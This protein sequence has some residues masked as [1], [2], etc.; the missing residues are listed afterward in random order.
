MTPTIAHFTPTAHPSWVDTVRMVTARAKTMMPE[1]TERLE[2]AME[3]VLYGQVTPAADGHTATVTS[4][5]DTDT[6]TVN[7]ECTCP[8]AQYRQVVCKHRLAWR[9]YQRS[10]E[11]LAVLDEPTPVLTHQG[12][13]QAQ[14]IQLIHGQPFVRYAGLLAMA[15]EAG[16]KRLSATF[17]TVTDT[18]ALAEATAAFTDGRTF[19]ECADATPENVLFQV[20][21]HFARMA[22]TRAKARALRDAL[23][24]GMCAV[25]ELGH[26]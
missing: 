5:H 6:Y 2:K 24:I 25:E 19:T 13:I 7:G 23:N 4:M 22:L 8:D 11:A 3:L 1:Q 15:H 10:V 9:L 20:R 26:E 18:L 12:T 21:P 14:F 16:L 17:I